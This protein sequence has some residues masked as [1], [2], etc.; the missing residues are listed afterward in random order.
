L[1]DSSFI[2]TS[3]AV[4][5]QHQAARMAMEQGNPDVVLQRADLARDGRL[6][7]MQRLGR[8]GEGAGLR[9]GVKHA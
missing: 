5:G 3:C 4:L 7:Q 1:I 9:R 6:R 8:M 2:S